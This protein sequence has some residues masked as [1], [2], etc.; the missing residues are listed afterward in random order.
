MEERNKFLRK[1]VTTLKYMTYIQNTHR[2]Q[3]FKLTFADKNW[4]KF[5][6]KEEL[7]Y[8][9]DVGFQEKFLTNGALDMI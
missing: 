8:K 7:T 3:S 4:L 6:L 5:N 2:F 1:S 9:I